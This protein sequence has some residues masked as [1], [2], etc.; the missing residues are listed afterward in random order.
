MS[1]A[2]PDPAGPGGFSY[3][4]LTPIYSEP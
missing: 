2:E 3:F 4:T 1:W